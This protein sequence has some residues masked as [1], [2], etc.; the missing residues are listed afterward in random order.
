MTPR[1]LEKLE[2][3]LL[4][5]ALAGF[6]QTVPGRDRALALMPALEREDVL[7]RWADVEPLRRLAS[8]G[9]RAPIGELQPLTPLFRAASLGQVLGG[10][11]LRQIAVLL[12]A[13]RKV[14]AFASDLMGRCTTLRR[15]KAQLY[16][17][18]QLLAAI[19]KAIAPD[20]ELNDD[21]SEEL[22]RIRK[23]KLAVRKR[24]EESLRKLLHEGELLQ[25]LQDD[26]FTVR[27][28]RYVVPMRLDGRGR[29]KGH[30]L[31]TS[32]SGQT[33]FIEPAS[34]VPIND[35]LQELD[36]EEKLEILR[37]FR[38]LSGRVAADEE[39]LARN[40]GELVELD[41]MSAEAQLAAEIDAGTVQLVDTPVLD[42]RDA[43]HPLLGR[44]VEGAPRK[45]AIGNAVSLSGPQ[46]SLI[47]SGPNA[48][49]KT[50]VLKTVGLLHLM[51]KAGLLLPAHESSRLFLFP[52]VWLEMGDAQ[53]LSANLS[54]FSGH[55]LG[56][57]PI[58]EQARAQDLV[59]LDELA[60]GTD[61]QTAS[62]IGTAILEDLA[63]RESTCLVTT[64][65]DALK[66][67]AIN[68][69]RFRNGSME[70]SLATLKPTYKL[71]LDVPGQSYGIEVAEQMGLPGRILARAKELRGTQVSALDQAVT[72]LME[73]RDEARQLKAGLEKETLAAQAEKDR[74]QQEVE[75]VRESRRKASQA[76]ADKYEERIRDMRFEFDELAKQMR[77]ALKEAQ[78]EAGDAGRDA[79]LTARRAAEGKLRDMENVVSE[80][81]SGYDVGDKLPGQPATRENLAPGAPVFVLP[82]KKAGSILKLGGGDDGIE[83][84]VGIIKLR[85][86]LHDLRLLSRGE[87]AGAPPKS[88]PPKGGRTGP[89]PAR[90]AGGPT[91]PAG[92]GPGATGTGGG[93]AYTLQTSTNSVDLR[94]KDAASAIE[95]A[96]N[97]IDRALLR[98]EPAVVLIHGHGEG[99]LKAAVRDALRSNCPYDV[100]FRAGLDQEGGDG[101]T[102]VALK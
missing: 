102:I 3:P 59:L 41:G 11:D 84:E 44:A 71:I 2:W 91:P 14:H 43:R 48:G 72:Q 49:G 55:L 64:H 101:V 15:F 42:L 45:P 38:E 68:D 31:D 93:I 89:L 69:H 7:T 79:M 34:I 99:T 95:A 66:G 51:A 8:Q 52:R 90:Q 60:V 32:A 37:I 97:F 75:L 50:V 26:F 35:Q 86:S 22:Q 6:C 83:V 5:E 53:N 27:N 74:W 94:G 92:G 18:P 58:L 62:A 47:I 10:P 100:R 21:A 39:A 77:Q 16:P 82:L 98:G 81:S 19:N 12:E 30:I 36:L 96:W 76:L 24:I 65:F 4:V 25:Y 67:L 61:P 54:T 56:L 57:K 1:V 85:V 20:G 23:A 73:A 46:R 9:Y 13:T 80:I 40:F 70:F 88:T 29:V 28:E 78:K 87:A 17:I 33:L 63:G